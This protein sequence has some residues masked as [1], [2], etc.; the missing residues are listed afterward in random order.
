MEID[1][2][3][4]RESESESEKLER[5][6]TTPRITDGWMEDREE[7]SRCAIVHQARTTVLARQRPIW[8]YC[9]LTDRQHALKAKRSRTSA[10][11]LDA[12][13]TR[14][15]RSYIQWMSVSEVPAE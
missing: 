7:Y 6:K 10:K 2:D 5:F 14:T 13:A 1:G 12:M 3:R 8:R 15:M 4:D 9:T 11:R